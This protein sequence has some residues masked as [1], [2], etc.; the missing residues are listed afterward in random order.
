MHAH[1]SAVS[2]ASVFLA[3]LV[4]GTLWRLAAAH[5]VASSNTTLQHLGQAMAFQY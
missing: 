5:M 4:W 2:A 1:F 3:V